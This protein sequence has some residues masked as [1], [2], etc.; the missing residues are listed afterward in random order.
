MVESGL[1]KTVAVR[2]LDGT[3][4]Q[5]VLADDRSGGQGPHRLGTELR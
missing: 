2:F 3:V 1:P 4:V 5:L